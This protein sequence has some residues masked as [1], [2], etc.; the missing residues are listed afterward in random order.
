[1]KGKETQHYGFV[2]LYVQSFL[3]GLKEQRGV[4]LWFVRLYLHLPFRGEGAE[5][6]ST[7]GLLDYMLTRSFQV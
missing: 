4:A 5:G 1:M 7:M 3:S 2:R 6:C